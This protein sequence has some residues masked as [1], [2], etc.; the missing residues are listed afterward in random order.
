[1][2]VI[3]IRHVDRREGKGRDEMT[4]V[5][6]AIRV[7][8]LQ[9]TYPAGSFGLRTVVGI[10]LTPNIPRRGI[11]GSVSSPGILGNTLRLVATITGTTG[12]RAVSSIAAIGSPA[13][14]G[15][16]TSAYFNAWGY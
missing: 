9:A 16:V 14:A 1:M 8:S 3:D 11:Y 2:P 7:S 4:D 12:T 10:V 6:G 5:A 15:T 13:G